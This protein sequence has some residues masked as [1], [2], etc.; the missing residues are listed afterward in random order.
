MTEPHTEISLA[1]AADFE[2]WVAVLLSD[3][4]PVLTG[5]LTAP[6]TTLR[7]WRAADATGQIFR[8]EFIAR[9]LAEPELMTV[10]RRAFDDLGMT[11]DEREM[12]QSL[13]RHLVGHTE[14]ATVQLRFSDTAHTIFL[15][16]QSRPCQVSTAA[17]WQL[18]AMPD[19]TLPF[20]NTTTGP[21]DIRVARNSA[22]HL[23]AQHSARFATP[24]DP[25]QLGPQ[26]H[27]SDVGWAF[28]FPWSTTSWYADGTSPVLEPGTKGPIVVVKDTGDTWLLDSLS[29][30]ESQL[31]EYADANGYRH[32]TPDPA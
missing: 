1:R 27:V 31:A 13:G 19:A 4:W 6:A 23:L 29:S 11:P 26:G 32:G 3:W 22:R 12:T 7:A 17:G 30:Y 2:S 24:A 10:A 9:Q 25:F 8:V 21:M 28:V 16:L 15:R 5:G 20:P 18:S 14:D